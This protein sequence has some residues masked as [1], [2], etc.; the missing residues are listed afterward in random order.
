MDA[1][2]RQGMTRRR[3]QETT[4]FGCAGLA[5][6]AQQI[7]ARI[8]RQARGASGAVFRSCSAVLGVLRTGTWVLEKP[9]F[10][11]GLGQRSA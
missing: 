5:V 2:Q 10:R 11:P 7:S 8:Q 9:I 4:L 3:R 1:V 6:H